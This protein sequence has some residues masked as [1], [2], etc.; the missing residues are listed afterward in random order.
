MI[1]ANALQSSFSGKANLLGIVF[2][3]FNK[4]FFYISKKKVVL[5]CIRTVNA[6]LKRSKST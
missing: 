2:Q 3:V 4:F 6:A 5:K 1:N